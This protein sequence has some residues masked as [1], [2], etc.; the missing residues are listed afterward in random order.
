ML[1]RLVEDL[2]LL[3]LAD[4]GQL[5]LYVAPL[6]LEAFLQ[7]IVEAHQ[8]HAQERGVNLALQMSPSLPL[9]LADRDRLAQ[10]MGNVLGNALQYVPRGGRVTV[11]AT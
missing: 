4:A 2:R 5:R 8:P 10:V 7:K 3:A 9:V 6:D 1:V 11:Q